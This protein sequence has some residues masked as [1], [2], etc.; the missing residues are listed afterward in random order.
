MR[1]PLRC[2]MVLAL[3]SGLAAEAGAQSDPTKPFAEYPERSARYLRRIHAISSNAGTMTP[4][5][6]GGELEEGRLP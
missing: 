5:G 4:P 6:G 1:W 3:A 2:T